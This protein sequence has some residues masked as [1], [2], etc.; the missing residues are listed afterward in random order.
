ML[1]GGVYAT[2]GQHSAAFFLPFLHAT[3]Q[4]HT[5]FRRCFVF[6]CLGLLASLLHLVW[7]TGVEGR[8]LDLLLE[9]AKIAVAFG[10]ASYIAVCAETT[11]RSRKR[12][13]EAMELA[14]KLIGHLSHSQAKLARSAEQAEQ[15]SRA[16]GCLLYTSPSPRDS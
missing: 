7:L 4:T 15:A 14:R 16:K 8:E 5:G 2:G 6:A 9:F 11:R 13:S 1:A 10:M 12:T 3:D